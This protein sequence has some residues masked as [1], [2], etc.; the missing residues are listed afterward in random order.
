MS[1][2]A[3]NAEPNNESKVIS[4][5]ERHQKVLERIAIQTQELRTRRNPNNTSYTRKVITPGQNDLIRCDKDGIDVVASQHDK[6]IA[7]HQWHIHESFKKWRR[8]KLMRSTCFVQ[9]LGSFRLEQE[10]DGRSSVISDVFKASNF[11]FPLMLMRHKLH[12]TI[13][14]LSK[15]NKNWTYPVPQESIPLNCRRKGH[16]C[17][18]CVR[19]EARWVLRNIRCLMRQAHASSYLAE[20]STVINTLSQPE[21]NGSS[22]Q[23]TVCQH[24]PIQKCVTRKPFYHQRTWTG[25]AG[26][27]RTKWANFA[28]GAFVFDFFSFACI[29][30]RSLANNAEEFAVAFATVSPIA[31]D[32]LYRPLERAS[33]SDEHV[34]LYDTQNEIGWF[35]PKRSLQLNLAARSTL[36]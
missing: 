4:A 16:A 5:L 21:V 31:T 30:H 9:I 18:Q 24:G 34:L 7:Q 27:L 20:D 11:T 29:P 3:P 26:V 32:Q 2:S 28:F 36:F 17:G 33:H 23:K 8:M 10:P 15:E 22:L 13:F 1:S 6:W 19:P 35:V 14:E 25:A 12:H